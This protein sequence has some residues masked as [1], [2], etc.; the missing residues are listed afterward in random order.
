MAIQVGSYNSKDISLIVG[1]KSIESFFQ[2]TTVDVEKSEDDV[3]MT[4]GLNGDVT[5]NS[6]NDNTY[7]ATFT[8]KSDSEDNGYLRGLRASGNIFAC[9]YENDATGEKMTL[10]GCRFQKNATKSDGSELGGREWVI[11]VADGEDLF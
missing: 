5:Y 8:V 4:K 9:F 11:M 2:D 7:T 6:S 10:N 3:T 1:T